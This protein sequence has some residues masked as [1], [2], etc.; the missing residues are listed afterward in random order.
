MWSNHMAPYSEYFYHASAY[1]LAGEI[2]RPVRQSIDAQA[3]TT[4]S[5]SGG[6]GANNFGKF[7]VDPF[8]YFDSAYTEVGGSF[9]E[10]HNIHTTY[11][12]AVVEGLNIADVV[13]ADRV[14]ARMVS[15]SPEVGNEDGE[16]SYDI[17][18]SHFDNLRIA[19]HLIDVK[20]AT[21]TFN[22]H[23]TYSKLAKAYSNGG[24]DDLLP[25]G[26]QDKKRLDALASAESSYRALNGIGGRIKSWL[27]WKKAAPKEDGRSYLCS[28]A[29]HLD[30][31]QTV[32]ESELQGFG[33]IILIPKFG[34]VRLGEV[35]IHPDYRRLIMFRVQMCSGAAGSTD[36]GTT[37]TS[38]GRPPMP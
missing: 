33:G 31:Q 16:H 32:G 1:G 7:S 11:A 8:I 24:A 38:G 4:L 15:Y 37:T 13:T 2:E 20:L 25:W 27:N 9:D 26:K 28:A 14:V 18:G 29:G 22:Q 30:L 17:T 6:R 36:G 35:I 10:D 23:D 3:A 19:G 34:V 21:H 12:Y 5:S